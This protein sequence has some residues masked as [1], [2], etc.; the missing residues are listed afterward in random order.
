MLA[1]QKDIFFSKIVGAIDL[2][3]YEIFIKIQI[4]NNCLSHRI[5]DSFPRIVKLKFLGLV[6]PEGLSQLNWYFFHD[7]YFI[8]R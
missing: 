8:I 4:K 6:G 1:L 5:T 7:F 2:T 3:V